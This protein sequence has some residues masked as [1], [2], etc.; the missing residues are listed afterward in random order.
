MVTFFVLS[1]D[2]VTAGCVGECFSCHENLIGDKD[3]VSL[4]TCYSCHDEKKASLSLK[5]KTNQDGGC[6]DRCFTC[7]MDWP[8]N[9]FHA[10]LDN[11]INCH[12]R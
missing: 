10:D 9:S 4:A 6:G 11:C 12:G 3:H 1:E 8:K 5:T 7:H 2:S